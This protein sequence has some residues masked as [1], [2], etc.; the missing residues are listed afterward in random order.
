MYIFIFPALGY[1]IGSIS[2]AIVVSRML[3]ISDPRQSGSGNPGT[4]NVLRLGGKKAA[5]I[6]LL[7]DVLKG[8]L[9]VAAAATVATDAHVIALTALGCL[10]GHL[11]PLYYGFKGGKGVATAIG[12]YLGMAPLIGLAVI[13]LWLAVAGIT[14]YSSAA[15]LS[16][17]AAAP[18][19]AG[20]ISG[21]AWLVAAA[22][23]IF[24][25]VAFSHKDNIRRL[26]AGKEDKINLRG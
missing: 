4:T 13:A 3:G 22:A 25:L 11:Y 5:A 1:L 21:D 16:A 2:A 19:L 20:V 14:R 9:P 24:T 8:T 26:L 18:V 23:V 17:M 7:G 10:L 12:V 6:T 15:S